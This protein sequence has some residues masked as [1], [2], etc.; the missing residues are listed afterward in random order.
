VTCMNSN[1]NIIVGVKK[2]DTI[3]INVV[4]NTPQCLQ[5]ISIFQFFL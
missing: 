4:S 1:E 3:L 5:N 2:K